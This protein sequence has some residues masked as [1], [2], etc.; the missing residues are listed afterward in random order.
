M[1]VLITKYY[2]HK[3]TFVAGIHTPATTK[4]TEKEKHL[5]WHIRFYQWHWWFHCLNKHCMYDLQSESLDWQDKGNQLSSVFMPPTRHISRLLPVWAL[6]P[7]ASVR[8]I[9]S[10]SL[11]LVVHVHLTKLHQSTSDIFLLSFQ[12][13][14][15]L[16][17]MP[18]KEHWAQ[19]TWFCNLG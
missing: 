7:Q 3:K 2:F 18:L 10:H 5:C 11:G 19:V 15:L 16:N 6:Q 12:Q 17:I 13:M 8:I 14:W 4:N 9:Y 1:I